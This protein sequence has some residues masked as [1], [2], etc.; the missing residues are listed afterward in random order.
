[1]RGLQL[2]GDHKLT[3]HLLILLQVNIHTIDNN[4]S[5]IT[6]SGLFGNGRHAA[7]GDCIWDITLGHA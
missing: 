6:Q 3:D 4:L 5:V 1:M 2:I 7:A